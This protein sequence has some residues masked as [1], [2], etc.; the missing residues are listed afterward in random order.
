MKSRL[1]IASVLG[2]G[3]LLSHASL[4]PGQSSAQRAVAPPASRRP[5][6]AG[7]VLP[8]GP[9]GEAIRYGER[10]L[11]QTRVAAKEYVGNALSCTSCHLDKGRRAYSS[12]WVGI[13][14][15]SPNTEAATRR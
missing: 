8:D 11:T 5:A 3:L 6:P 1:A 7:D 14:A 2:V 10:I 13:W 4:A 12:P 15:S 9:L